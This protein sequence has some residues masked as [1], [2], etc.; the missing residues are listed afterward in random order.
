MPVCSL[1]TRTQSTNELGSDCVQG[2]CQEVS[3]PRGAAGQSLGGPGSQEASSEETSVPGY[4]LAGRSL[5]GLA[6]G[7]GGAWEG[8]GPRDAGPALPAAAEDSPTVV[9]P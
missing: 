3:W 2:G 6:P 8:G 9:G 7:P 5:L 4:L 1:F